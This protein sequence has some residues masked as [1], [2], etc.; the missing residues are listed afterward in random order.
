MD[1]CYKIFFDLFST[2]ITTKDGKKPKLVKRNQFRATANQYR[3]KV[4]TDH[5]RVEK[6]M[7]HQSTMNDKAID[8]FRKALDKAVKIATIKNIPPIKGVTLIICSAGKSLF[9]GGAIHK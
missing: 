2:A 4:N 7:K 6:L 1:D 8:A 9:S 3:G 5:Y